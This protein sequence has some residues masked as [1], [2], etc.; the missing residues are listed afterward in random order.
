[1]RE[2]R[3]PA[4]IRTRCC[5]G[6][7]SESDIVMN[8]I[9]ATELVL[10]VCSAQPRKGRKRVNAELEQRS[11]IDENRLNHYQHGSTDKL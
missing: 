3:I 8:M 10:W 4:S 1:M 7:D 11:G 5:S 6:G 2:E 9:D